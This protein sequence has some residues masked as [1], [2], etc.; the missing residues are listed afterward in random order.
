MAAPHVAGTIALMMDAA[1]ETLPLDEVRTVLRNTAF[2]SNGLIPGCDNAEKWCGSMIDAGMA[3]AVVAG[4]IPLPPAPPAPPEPP[5]PTP[6]VKDVV[7]NL[8]AMPANSDL[9]FVLDVPAGQGALEFTLG[10][11][12]SGD[13]DIYVQYNQRPTNSVWQCRPW[14]GGVVT[15]VCSFV[16]PA[17]GAWHVRV[18]AY[19]AS[20]G[21]TLVGTYGG[22]PPP[23]PPPPTTTELENGVTVSGINIAEDEDLYFVLDVPEE[24]TNLS[25]QMTGAGPGDADLYVLHDGIP[26]NA[27]Y[28]C[29]PYLTGSNELC[30]FPT[31]EAGEWF[32]RLNGYAAASGLTLTGSYDGGPSGGDAPAN[33]RGAYAFALKALRIRVPLYWDGGE[34]AQVDI[35]RNGVTVATVANTGYFMDTFTASAPGAGSVSYQVCNAGTSE[36]G[37]ATV[38]YTARR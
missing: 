13:S 34:G 31:P 16:S 3:V 35:K 38:D 21:Y 36:C 2:A 24:A 30:T 10:A 15:E 29:R 27:V 23:P 7:V 26:T 28:D 1:G 8:P 12:T 5:P 4:D 33:V 6:L 22:D 32:V 9:Y 20:A 14:T 17:A 18:N 11:G 19:T 37:S 25:F